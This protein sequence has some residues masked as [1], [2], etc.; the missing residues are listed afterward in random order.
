MAFKPAVAPI[1]AGVYPLLNKPEFQPFTEE[2]VQLL[3]TAGA[4]VRQS[5]RLNCISRF[6]LNQDTRVDS[7][8]HPN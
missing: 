6:S 5:V 1:K 2:I 4:C 3:T 7:S 8:D